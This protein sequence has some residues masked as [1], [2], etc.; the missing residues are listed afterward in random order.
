MYLPEARGT[1]DVDRE[2][3]VEGGKD[4]LGVPVDDGDLA[5]IPLD[6]SEVVLPVPLGRALGLWSTGT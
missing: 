1:G 2:A 3:G 6:Y 4:L 5:D